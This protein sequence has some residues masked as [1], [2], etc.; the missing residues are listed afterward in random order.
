MRTPD[1]IENALLR[2]MPAGISVSAQVE[3][4]EKLDELCGGVEV[5]MGR[6][7]LAVNWKRY[8]GIA[9]ALTVGIF[10]ALAGYERGLVGNVA[11]VGREV[12][13]EA[14]PADLVF[15]TGSDRLEDVSDEGVFVDS[16]GSAIRKVRIRLVDEQQ[17]RDEETGIVVVVSEPREEMLIL[18]VNSF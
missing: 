6:P 8:V 4:E 3:M 2:L 10:V 9:A 5:D 13:Q 17:M 15:L 16:A 14:L 12:F 1:E 11:E 7:V 18:P